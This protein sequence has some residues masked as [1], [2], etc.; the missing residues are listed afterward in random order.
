[1]VVSHDLH[2]PEGTQHIEEHRKD[3]SEWDFFYRNDMREILSIFKC[4][5]MHYESTKFAI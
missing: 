2:R 1:M 4:L 3:V 5:F